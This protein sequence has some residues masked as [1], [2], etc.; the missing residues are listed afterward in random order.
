MIHIPGDFKLEFDFG[1][2]TLAPAK[3]RSISFADNSPKNKPASVNAPASSSRD[4]LSKAASEV[5]SSPPRYFRHRNSLIVIS[6]VGDRIT[7]H[8]LD[9]NK[10]HSLDLFG[11]KD[12]PLE[13][14]PIIAGNLA[15]LMLK[16]PKLTRIAVA[17]TAGGTWHAQALQRPFDG[18]AVPIISSGVAVYK[19]GRDVYAYGADAGRWDLVELPEGLQAMPVVAGGTVTIEGRG[20]IYTFAGQTGK[21]NHVDVRTILDSAKAEKK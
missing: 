21:W 5:E 3:L 18:Q 7:L 15:A 16:G 10:S 17:D 19:L 12:A 13:V 20:H 8:N 11:S 2:L 1:T 6:A 14:T 4:E 9:T